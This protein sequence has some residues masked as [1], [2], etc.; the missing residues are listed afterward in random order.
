MNDIKR[1][2]IFG[3]GFSK[4]AGIPLTNNL[5]PLLQ[6]KHH[7]DEMQNWLSG[8]ADRLSWLSNDEKLTSSKLNI[9][10]VF[11]YANFDI[12]THRIKH[13]LEPVG[14]NDGPG[15][16]WNTAKNIGGWLS[17]LEEDLIDVIFEHDKKANL[18][19]I[20]RWAETVNSNDSILTFNYDT[21]VER[22]IVEIGKTFNHGFETENNDGISV[23]KLHGSIDWV[24]AHRNGNLKKLDLLFDKENQNR[25][26][27]DTNAIE[28][29]YRLW[30]CRSSEQCKKWLSGRDIQNSSI[31]MTFG[32]AGLG[33]YKQLHQVPGLGEVWVNGMKSLYNADV[34][35]VVGFSLSDFD[36]MAQMHFA[37]VARNRKKENNPLKVIVIDPFIDDNAKKRFY[38][39]FR[40]VD[41]KTEFHENVDW[42]KIHT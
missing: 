25:D 24:V 21:L 40:N 18:K 38:N 23:Y 35:V 4:P 12:E 10:Q 29:D 8:L 32:M 19:P 42:S 14:R 16:S 37:E 31:P 33:S 41:F 7:D 27:E 3:A 2:F 28:D 5:L 39:L 9:E 1:V 17:N 20:L 13:H 36:A 15:T 26:D 30:R 22:A 11:H 34:A 6:E